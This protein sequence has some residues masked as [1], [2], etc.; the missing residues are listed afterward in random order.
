MKFMVPEDDEE[1]S[2]NIIPLFKVEPGVTTDSNAF[3]AARYVGIPDGIIQRSIEVA[4]IEL[5]SNGG[6]SSF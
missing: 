2:L 5:R 3:A 4:S 6:L 1:A